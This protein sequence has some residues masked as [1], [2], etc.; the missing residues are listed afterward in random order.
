MTTNRLYKE[1]ILCLKSIASKYT[2]NEFTTKIMTNLYKKLF[3]YLYIFL[4]HLFLS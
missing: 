3:F 1:L 2:S 4:K